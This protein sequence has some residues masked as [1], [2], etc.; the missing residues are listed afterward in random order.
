MC[1]VDLPSMNINTFKY[2]SDG[3]W[4]VSCYY[5]INED[6][7]LMAKF[8]RSEKGGNPLS[9]TGFYS[10]IEDWN[11]C[12]DAKGYKIK[13]KARFLN[14]KFDQKL[15]KNAQFT[16]VETGCDAFGADLARAKTCENGF[17]LET[18]IEVCENNTILH[19]TED[20]A[21]GS[22]CLLT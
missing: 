1:L 15:L 19:C 17:V 11:R 7:Q 8:R 18:G 3:Y 22:S 20:S 14:P 13:R 16:K 5:S 10:F 9:K 4:F 2:F 6:H 12:K 21:P